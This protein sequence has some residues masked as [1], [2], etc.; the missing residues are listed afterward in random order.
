MKDLVLLVLALVLTAV[1]L[2]AAVSLSTLLGAFYGYVIDYFLPVYAAA[3][4]HVFGVQTASHAGAVIGF[5]VSLFWGAK[6][7]A[8][9]TGD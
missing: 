3:I 6:T 9:S 5:V 2:I 8:A 4:A 7:A 1:L